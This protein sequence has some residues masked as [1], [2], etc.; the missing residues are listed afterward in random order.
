MRHR[1][2]VV[3]PDIYS[4]DRVPHEAYRPT[5]V[6]S[7]VMVPIRTNDP[8]GAIGNYWDHPYTATEKDVGTAPTSVDS[9]GVN[10]RPRLRR[11]CGAVRTLS[12]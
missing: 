3:I 2:A 10:F 5:F 4:D 6:K 7:M 9:R 11:V 1:E 12:G 8:I